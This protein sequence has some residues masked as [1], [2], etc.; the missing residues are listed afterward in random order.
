MAVMLSIPADPSSV[1]LA[2]LVTSG[3]GAQV[4]A[5]VD[6][7][8][9]LRTLVDELC[10][11]LVEHAE[12]TDAV[13]VEVSMSDDVVH[14]SASSTKRHEWAPDMLAEGIVKVLA[15]RYDV[16]ASAERVSLAVEKRL[17]RA[18]A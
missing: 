4:G 3:Y 18:L 10:S 13:V 9:D 15:D 17:E 6:E 2:R 14:I 5:S 1:R 12:P 11:M 16:E 8:D 7:V